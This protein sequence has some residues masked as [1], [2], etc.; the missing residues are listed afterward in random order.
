MEPYE[1]VEDDNYF[2][3]VLGSMHGDRLGEARLARVC[4]GRQGQ[5]V[6]PNYQIVRE[7]GSIRRRRGQ[8]HEPY[9][10]QRN[11]TFEEAHLSPG[12]FSYEDVQ[13]MI[14]ERLAK[15]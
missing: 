8:N 14:A 12:S 9:E 13:A 7:D 11:V 15:R 4:Y 2:R 1:M 6:Y 3:G 10:D 5:G